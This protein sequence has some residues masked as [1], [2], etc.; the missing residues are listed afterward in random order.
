MATFAIS[1]DETLGRLG[2]IIGIGPANSN[3]EVDEKHVH[4]R[5]GW[6][7]S[8]RIPRDA[9][10]EI[11]QPASLPS[12][13]GN[14]HRGVHGWGRTWTVNGSPTGGVRLTISPGVRARMLI[15]TITLETLFLS[16]EQPEAFVA[17]LR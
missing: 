11:V 5:M 6:A 14:V 3:V 10:H 8:A 2:N 15:F 1:F 16:L 17:S 12:R 7:F 4:V 13:Q 9:I